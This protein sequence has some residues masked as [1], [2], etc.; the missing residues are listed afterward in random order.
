MKKFLFYILV[1]K[2]IAWWKTTKTE[3]STWVA[4]DKTFALSPVQTVS[5]KFEE[6]CLSYCRYYVNCRSFKRNGYSL[7]K[8]EFKNRG[9]C[10]G[11]SS[12]R[13]YR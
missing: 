8:T 1:I 13:F 11:V 9:S 6:Q 12:L 3:H 10:L 2:V 5:V 4:T 7:F